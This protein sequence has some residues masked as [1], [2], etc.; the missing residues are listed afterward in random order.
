MKHGEKKEKKNNEHSISDNFKQSHMCI[1]FPQEKRAQK[2]KNNIMAKN[3]KKL[4]KAMNP[5]VQETQ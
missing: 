1:K 5:Q 3:V 4:I 2:L